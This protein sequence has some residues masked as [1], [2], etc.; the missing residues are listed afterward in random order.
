MRKANAS[1]CLITVLSICTLYFWLGCSKDS[2]KKSPYSSTPEFES[3]VTI[4][5]QPYGIIGAQVRGDSNLL[6]MYTTS[7][8]LK[9]YDQDNEELQRLFRTWLDRLYAFRNKK[10]AVGIVVRRGQIDLI[11]ASRDLK[12]KVV[13]SRM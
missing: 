12:G 9:T 11:H 7:D 10:E 6:L 4:A 1:K 3:A 2:G 8:F 13:F 5:F